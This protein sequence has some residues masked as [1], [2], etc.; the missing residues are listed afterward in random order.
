M[1]L[2]SR[3]RHVPIVLLVAVPVVLLVVLGASTPSRQ[4][5]MRP[6]AQDL[7]IVSDDNT[8]GMQLTYISDIITNEKGLIFTS[9]STEG[10]I[11]VFDAN[12]R[13]LRKFGRKGQGPGE[14]AGYMRLGATIGDTVVVIDG[15]HNVF[16]FF[17]SDGTFIRMLQ[18]RGA[19]A[20]RTVV[21]PLL[22]DR[23]LM[24]VGFMT[25]MPNQLPDSETFLITDTLGKVIKDVAHGRTPNFFFKN[26]AVGKEIRYQPFVSAVQYAGDHSGT[27]G[28]IALPYHEWNGKPGQV[29]LLIV[30]HDGI[31]S[32]RIVSL[33]AR[34]TTT[35]DV[36]AWISRSVGFYATDPGGRGYLP[37]AAIEKGLRDSVIVSDYLPVIDFNALR[38]GRDGCIWVRPYWSETDWTV[39]A[40]T[41]TRTF[42]VRLPAGASRWLYEV[43][44]TGFWTIVPDSDG[45][46]VVTRYRFT[47]P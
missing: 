11:R 32:E 12:G 25:P 16:M 3:L 8:P 24:R 1:R 19:W 23:A 30:N 20:D 41:G 29:K 4:G 34:K 46:P 21:T 37:V 10:V 45:L 35:A 40:P 17:G 22:P 14:F 18:P 27:R 15:N 44:M 13:F 31:E 5:G 26:R 33:E 28:V 42:T 39:I 43:S 2:A 38:M 7:R 47:A 9:H 36:N 6:Y